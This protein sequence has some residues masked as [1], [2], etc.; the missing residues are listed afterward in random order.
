VAEPDPLRR[1]LRARALGAVIKV[2]PWIPGPAV[3]LSLSA[4]AAVARRSRLGARARANLELAL[5]AE[6]DEAA[7]ERLLR[8]TFAHSARQFREWLR[9]ARGAAPQDRSGAWIEELVELD[10]SVER[11]DEVLA[12]GRGALIFTAHLGNWEL[13]AARLRRR[14]HL[15]A[16]V[17]RR[18]PRS[19]GSAW[20]PRV[21]RGYGLETL[22]Q[23]APPRRALEVLRRGE[24]L[25]VL[26]DL[27]VRRLDGEFVPFFGQPALT[28][29]AP[30]ALA[31]AARLPLLPVRCVATGPRSYRLS[32]D[33]P[34]ELD[35]GLPR[36]QARSELLERMN[37]T[38]ERWIRETPEQW[39]WHQHR[40]RTRP[41]ERPSMPLAE[42]RRRE[43][44][45]RE[46]EP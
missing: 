38:F 27:E 33:P 24:I 43:L 41:G 28:M 16:V 30:A 15:G 25:G 35:P 19:P 4:A 2:A 40:W 29:S 1:R 10:P 23:D 42:R 31:R 36:N 22:A 46:E 45:A 8:D 11:L 6:L 17:G 14:G 18:H 20:L 32:V 37:L 13:L 39:A 7:R 5:G 3:N 34:L 21:R 12:G 26:T 9:L 44:A